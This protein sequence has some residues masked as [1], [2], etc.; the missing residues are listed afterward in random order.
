MNIAQYMPYY[1]MPFNVSKDSFDSIFGSAKIMYCA[2]V[3]AYLF[4]SLADIWLFGIIKKA[5]KGI[6][7]M[8]VTIISYL[9]LS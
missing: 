8:Y 9:H 7:F 4:G 2:S 1:D 5:T 3:T 6:L